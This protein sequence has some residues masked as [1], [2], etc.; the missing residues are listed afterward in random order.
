MQGYKK[1][2][3]ELGV[4][5]LYE[6]V[7]DIEVKR[8]KIEFVKTHK[9]AHIPCEI[10]VN[11]AGPSAPQNSSSLV[12]TRPL[13]FLAFPMIVSGREIL[14]LKRKWSKGSRKNNLTF[15]HL[16][17]RSSSVDLH[18]LSPRNPDWIWIPVASLI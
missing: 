15:S 5:Y 8:K 7:T 9:G 10:V 4:E 11:A 18:S 12:N 14:F 2:G 13:T 16:I 3:K 6:E 1:K 17:F